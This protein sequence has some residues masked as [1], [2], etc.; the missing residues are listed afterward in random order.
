MGEHV[1]RTAVFSLLFGGLVFWK[2]NMFC[3]GWKLKNLSL[4][5]KDVV[6]GNVRVPPHASQSSNSV[7]C[8]PSFRRPHP[9]SHPCPVPLSRPSTLSLLITLTPICTRS[10][11]HRRGSAKKDTWG[12]ELRWDRFQNVARTQRT[13]YFEMCT[14]PKKVSAWPANSIQLRRTE[15][16]I[17][18]GRENHASVDIVGAV[19]FVFVAI[20]DS[21]CGFL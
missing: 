6:V 12:A 7:F 19:S 1:C 8:F 21:S 14:R 16:R 9:S 18:R 5:L 13:S 11:P 10:D 3:L 4:P 15:K 20:V 17:K 2:K